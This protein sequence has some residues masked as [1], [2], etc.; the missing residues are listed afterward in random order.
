MRTKGDDK[1]H[2]LGRTFWKDARAL[3]KENSLQTENG[4]ENN[5][6]PYCV[7]YM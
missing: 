2:D 5:D 3:A 6:R 4:L 1:S 7:A